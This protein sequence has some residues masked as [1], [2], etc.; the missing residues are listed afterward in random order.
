MWEGT[1]AHDLL[2]A[3]PLIS[4]TSDMQK[5]KHV[6]CWVGAKPG[7]IILSSLQKLLIFKKNTIKIC[8]IL[9]QDIKEQSLAQKLDSYLNTVGI[10]G[11]VTAVCTAG[12]LHIIPCEAKQMLGLY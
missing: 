10:F 7:I 9:S 8:C 5:V 2:S 4:E 3:V 1:E 11:S 6:L 12:P